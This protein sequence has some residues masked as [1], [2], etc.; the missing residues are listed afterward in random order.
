VIVRAPGKVVLAGAYAVL[1]G[2]PAWVAAVDRYVVA[3]SSRSASFVT[4][5]VRQA[6][7]DSAEQAAPWFDASELR[8]SGGGGDAGSDRKLG[9]GSSAAILV[10]S[11]AALESA[12]PP[13]DLELA[14]RVFGRAL[15]AHRAAQGGGSGIDVAASAFGGV[16]RFQRA[17]ADEL[18]EIA[19]RTLP[20]GLRIDVWS[21]PVSAST[22]SMVARVS[23]LWR[24][25]NLACRSIIKSLRIAS[26]AC[27]RASN[28]DAWL[29]VCREQLTGLTALG[30]LAGIPIVTADVA[31]FQAAVRER[32]AVVLPSGAGGG[33]VFLVLTSRAD[34]PDLGAITAAG[35]QLGLTPLHLVLGARGVHA[36]T[37]VPSCAPQRNLRS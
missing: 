12:S 35:Q 7:G 22:S 15:V 3:D 10:A 13:H 9:L 36:V 34:D 20:D 5:E 33:D 17:A 28:A 14:N 1:E 24:A 29:S 11:L 4:P 2:A 8:D 37:T 6:L 27:D 16:L 25:G 31:A 26:E 19:A 30:E 21:S 32:G 23:A 18:P